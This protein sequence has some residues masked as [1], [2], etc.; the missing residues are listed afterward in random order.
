MKGM[1]NAGLILVIGAIFIV[2]YFLGGYGGLW[3]PVGF[4]TLSLTQADF[5]STNQFFNEPAWILT[6]SQ[7]GLGQRAVGTFSKSQIGSQSGETP[8]YD[9]QL[10]IDYSEQ[11]CNYP[12][13]RS[14]GELQ[15]TKYTMRTWTCFF[16]PSQAE[17]SGHCTNPQFYGKFGTSYEC[18]CLDSQQLT[19]DVSLNIENPYVRTVSDVVVTAKTADYSTI[20]TAGDS[21]GFMQNGFVYYIWNGDLLR[22]SCPNQNNQYGFYKNGMWNVGTKSRYDNY[23][24][25]WQALNS[26]VGGSPTKSQI[27]NLLNTINTQADLTL[28]QSTF[29]DSIENPGSLTSAVIEKDVPSFVTSPV[30]TFYVKADWLGIEQPLPDIYILSATCPRFN[31]NG[32]IDF[33]LKN[34]G[35]SGNA[36]VW[37]TC[38]NPVT[39][40]FGSASNALEFGVNANSQTS[41]SIPISANVGQTTTRI[42]TLHSDD[43]FDED[44]YDVTCIADPSQVCTP[45][46]RL[47]T[48]QNTIEQCNQFGT[49]YDLVQACDLQT[50]ECRIVNGHPQCVAKG[51]VP[52]SGECAWWDIL[53]HL[54]NFGGWLGQVFNDITTALFVPLLLAFIILALFVVLLLRFG[55]IGK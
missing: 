52:P 8:K 50:E 35:E 19:G 4:T 45:G 6:V 46:Q 14:P 49:G 55:V 37:V 7:G 34:N 41:Q 21:Q 38:S 29:A 25:M 9:F 47:C 16:Q 51:V 33:T 36:R 27:Q 28:V 30:Y 31:T 26:L 22:G 13:I 54:N 53:C 44:T 12:I 20:D 18:F 17:A 39:S 15:V 48:A 3:S 43:G 11:S 40:N 32:K 24:N 23:V 42:C 1:G 2:V 10:D 5:T